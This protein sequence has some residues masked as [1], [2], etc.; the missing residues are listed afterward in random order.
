MNFSLLS[1]LLLIVPTFI[2]GYD[3]T[4]DKQHLQEAFVDTKY[5][6]YRE[7]K[8]RDCSLKPIMV[9][10]T[11]IDVCIEE[12]TISHKYNAW[13][14]E[15]SIGLTYHGYNTS[16]CS[17]D[18]SLGCPLPAS[19][20]GNPSCTSLTFLH[21][22]CQPIRN[23]DGRTGVGSFQYQVTSTP[24]VPLDDDNNSTNSTNNNSIEFITCLLPPCHHMGNLS[25]FDP[26]WDFDFKTKLVDQCKHS[27]DSSKIQAVALFGKITTDNFMALMIQINH[28]FDFSTDVHVVFKL[29]NHDKHKKV[30][31]PR[32]LFRL[33]PSQR[34]KGL[35]YSLPIPS[36]VMT[37]IGAFTNIIAKFFT[38]SGGVDNAI[39]ESCVKFHTIPIPVVAYA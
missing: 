8:T 34:S 1:L 21:Q 30:H 38:S 18:S 37:D 23:F 6:V 13:D 9:E 24:P 4:T 5:M 15:Y 17:G 33:D 3:L 14:S 29:S 36:D 25:H 12:E 32:L 31:S 20:R 39:L 27:P 26:I 7:W 22:G 2:L 11:P 10:I 16:D 28:S 19:V 35:S